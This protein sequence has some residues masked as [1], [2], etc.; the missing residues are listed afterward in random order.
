MK[1]TPLHTFSVDPMFIRKT[2]KPTFL[3]DYIY[4]L[5]SIA[6]IGLLAGIIKGYLNYISL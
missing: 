6:V 5:L 2:V 3:K 4:I 1:N